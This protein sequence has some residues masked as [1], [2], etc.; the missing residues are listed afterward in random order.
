MADAACRAGR[1]NAGAKD[2]GERR[3]SQKENSAPPIA[4]KPAH[5]SM[6][7]QR[8]NAQR[9][10]DL[11][12]AATPIGPY[13]FSR[14]DQILPSAAP[15]LQ[16]GEK[17]GA[18]IGKKKRKAAKKLAKRLGPWHNPARPFSHCFSR[19]CSR[20]PMSKPART[21]VQAEH[22]EARKATRKGTVERR[23]S[24]RPKAFAFQIDASKLSE[25]RAAWLQGLRDEARWLYNHLVEW[26]SKSFMD[27]FGFTVYPNNLFEWDHRTR[28]IEVLEWVDGQR[29][30]H[31]PY[32][33]KHLGSHMIQDIAERMKR[34]LKS[35]AAKRAANPGSKFGSLKFKT[36]VNIPLRE[37]GNT[38]R[39]QRGTG[40]LSRL[41][42]QGCG[43][44]RFHLMKNRAF[45]QFVARV[46][47]AP[48]ASFEQM[49][50]AGALEVSNAEIRFEGSKARLIV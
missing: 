44:E 42:L 6:C 19:L 22:R 15:V 36:N 9:L 26:S 8:H 38:F 27:D 11:K 33:L 2:S 39:I 5:V 45:S 28:D 23:K 43:K 21:T 4:Q 3:S 41:S 40:R 12:T 47:F 29:G 13:M 14:I 46:G 48:G 10:R 32:S 37:L 30:E 34:S 20:R 24:M 50:E 31:L 35:M 17:R 25:K 18:R 49:A 16:G 7:R 1:A